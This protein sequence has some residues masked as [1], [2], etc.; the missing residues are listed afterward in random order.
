MKKLIY[1]LNKCINLNK[2]IQIEIC[3]MAR[4]EYI[5][6]IMKTSE[7][8]GSI[9]DLI[10]S[11][12]IYDPL[13]HHFDGLAE[14]LRR[15]VNIDALLIMQAYRHL[16]N[17]H[18]ELTEIQMR[19]TEPFDIKKHAQIYWYVTGFRTLLGNFR[20]DWTTTES[21]KVSLRRMYEEA[22]MCEGIQ[23]ISL[24]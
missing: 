13:E 4:S 1:L 7:T 3:Q 17:I 6:K 2:T 9:H 23:L 16:S 8:I 14:L 11:D 21:S 22:C 19:A 20:F 18:K 12:T 24:K 10:K 15:I 5:S